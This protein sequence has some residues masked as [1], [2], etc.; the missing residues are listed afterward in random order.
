MLPEVKIKERYFANGG[1]M[2]DI[3][4][5]SLHGGRIHVIRL[6]YIFGDSI[7]QTPFY[8]VIK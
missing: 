3:W 7:E 2:P 5:T 8:E 6:E 4:L 1:H